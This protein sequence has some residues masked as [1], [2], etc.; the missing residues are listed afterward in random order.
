MC[1]WLI[2][3][4]CTNP[5]TPG[6]IS[7]KAPNSANL[8]TLPSITSPSLNSPWIDSNG[9]GK[10]SLIDNEILSE[11]LSIDFTFTL[12]SSPIETTSSGDLTCS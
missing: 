10:V 6:L 4:M 12:T 9:L 1:L 3:E 8:I 2:S 11:S 7:T 5:C